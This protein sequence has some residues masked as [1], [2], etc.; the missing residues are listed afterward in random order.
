MQFLFSCLG[1][2]QSSSWQH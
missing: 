2:Q 1:N